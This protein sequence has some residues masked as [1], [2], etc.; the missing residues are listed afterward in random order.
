MN[1]KRIVTAVFLAS[2]LSLVDGLVGDALAQEVKGIEEITV[3]AQKREESSQKVPISI[4]VLSERTIEN[5]GITNMQDLI[6]ELPGVNGFSAAGSKGNV[7]LSMRG[8]ITGNPSN[9][10]T[11]PAVGIYQDGVYL[12]KMVGAALDVAEL[13]RI[14]VL[15][16]PQG[17]LY[18]RN[19][20]AGAINFVTRKPTGEFGVKIKASFGN[21]DAQTYNVNLDLPSLDLHDAGELMANIGYQNRK[22]DALYSRVGGG[23]GFDSIDRDAYRIAVRWTGAER[24][25]ADYTHDSSK[26]DEKNLLEK[27]VGFTPLD[28]AGNVG[29]I[30][31]L[32]STINNAQLWAALPGSDPRIDTRLIP[33]MQKTLAK[34]EDVIRAG[35]GRPSRGGSDHP[36]SY[37]T[38]ASGNSLALSWDLGEFD[39]LGDI[40]IR[41]ITS[42]RKLNAYAYGD[43]ED[44]DS[45]LD[46]D[47]IG[48]MH[49]LVYATMAQLYGASNGAAYPLIDGVWSGID[50]IGAYHSKQDT[51]SKY[52]Q[53]S[54]EFNIIGANDQVEYVIG[55][56]YFDDDARYDRRAIFA[57]PLSG[58]GRQYYKT[59]T[60]ALAAFGQATWRPSEFDTRLAITGGLRYTK[61]RKDIVYDYSDVV[62]PF[63]VR[64]ANFLK[65]NS[66]FN[67]LS[68]NLTV[69][70][71]FTDD[72]NVFLR[73]ATGYRSGGFNGEVFN[74]QYDEETVRELEVGIKS[75]WLD[76]RARI[77][78]SLY[79]Y[80]Y[81]DLQVSQIKTDGGVATT[82]LSNAGEAKRWGGEVEMQLIPIDDLLLTLTYSFIS[83]D[84]DKYPE[85]CGTNVPVRCIDTKSYVKRR[86][87]QHQLGATGEYVFAQTEMG[88]VRGYIQANWQSSWKE[89]ELWSA[90]IG[91]D[92][93]IYPH[94]NMD[95]RL[96]VDA[97]LA[98]DNIPLSTGRATISLW[99][100]NLTND[101]YPVYGVNFGSMGIITESYGNPRTY[102]VEFRYEY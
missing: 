56:Y 101:D 57:A 83:G 43:L 98:L 12:G 84:F 79:T 10:S 30:D 27:I 100:K 23:D 33:S 87:P 62:T 69:G 94:I 8:I 59:T 61:E 68:G 76:K 50:A 7:S 70:Y 80:K 73:Y 49:D 40:T 78:A 24:F 64:P 67:N 93:V 39:G 41:S 54:Q 97:R 35:Q 89:T 75:D 72:L 6:G 74:N 48:A 55:A 34:Y 29:R 86:A 14:E 3:T 5:R 63:G 13:E 91:G 65:R 32:R 60:D 16:G 9:M 52:K 44:L 42:S 96:V 18:G 58:V 17:T 26:L 22:R 4:S 92:P 82:V 77:N 37:Y 15:R 2:S 28:S 81:K 85:L 1:K 71:Q 99:G 53:F 20:T 11:D 31:A 19:S 45:T 38:K 47:G 88:D 51:K 102:G 90:V 46:S 36:P 66:N 25:T 95:E 21:Y